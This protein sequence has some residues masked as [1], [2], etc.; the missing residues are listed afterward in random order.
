MFVSRTVRTYV[1]GLSALMAVVLGVPAVAKEPAPG[2][3]FLTSFRAG[4]PPAGFV[5]IC[6]RYAWVCSNGRGSASHGDYV[7]LAQ[8]I[9]IAVNREVKETTDAALYGTPEYWT[10]PNGAGDCEDF[11]LLKMQRLIEA[12]VPPAQLF[13]AVVVGATNETHVVLVLRASLADFVL[14]N[15]S[16]RVSPWQRTRYTF[17]KMQSA[18]NRSR[19]DIVLL[20]P[21]ATRN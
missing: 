5:G 9:N 17:I 1:V 13:L 2:S 14:D 7:G 16:A 6:A 20:G 12:G 15:L 19:W 8:S 21:R 3:A 18:S 11:A 10:L 4:P